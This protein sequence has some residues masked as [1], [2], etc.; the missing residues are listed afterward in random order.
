MRAQKILFAT[1]FS[2]VSDA[3]LPF[4]TSLARDWGATLLILH[5]QEPPLGYAHGHPGHVP[6]NLDE[7]KVLRLLHSVAPPDANVGYE[8]R[9]VTG[10]AAEEIVRMAE[11]EGVDMIVMGTH[12]RRGLN[13]LLMGSVA[14][15]VVRQARCPVLSVK[16]TVAV[17]SS[18]TSPSDSA[19]AAQWQMP[20][21]TRPQ[22][23]S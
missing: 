13:R 9:L 2:E 20:Y 8:Q 3:A 1:D 6:L 4:A 22:L 21:P 14:E 18:A 10:D 17:V 15:H 7:A 12:G 11:A 16:P 5:V 23:T 19:D